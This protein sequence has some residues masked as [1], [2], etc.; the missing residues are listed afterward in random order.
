[1]NA[2]STITA[3][4]GYLLEERVTAAAIRAKNGKIFTGPIHSVA[5]AA[6][7]TAGE[8]LSY[9][10]PAGQPISFAD[11]DKNAPYA[12]GFVTDTGRFI[13][14][15]EAYALAVQGG[16][17]PEKHRQSLNLRDMDWPDDELEA[18]AFS[19]AQP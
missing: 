14:R 6:A 17:S 2:R 3:I 11:L 12:E 19:G 4:V 8:D 7:K 13:D 1:V 16:M 18:K 10:L 9:P 15:E 5:I